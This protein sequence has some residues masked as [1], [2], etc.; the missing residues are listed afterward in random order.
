MSQAR[1]EAIPINDIYHL[2]DRLE[3]LLRDG[4]RVPLSAYLILNEEDCLDIIDQ[5][6]TAIPLEVKRGER[7]QQERGRIIAQAEEEAGRIVE[8]GREEAAKLADEHEIVK[9]ASQRAQTIIER[10]QHDAEKLRGEA[11]EYATGV[12]IS[13]DDQLSVLDGQIDG[14]LKTVRNGLKTLSRSHEPEPEEVA[15]EVGA[16]A[17]S[18]G[19]GD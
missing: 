13:L 6:R 7:V 18:P 19:A 2:I 10:A 8:L 14:L 15:N 5:M 16:T 11:D 9:A 4:V 1:K 12:L 17:P 3:R